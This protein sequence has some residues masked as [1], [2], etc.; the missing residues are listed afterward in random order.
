MFFLTKKDILSICEDPTRHSWPF[1]SWGKSR[2]RISEK[3]LEKVWPKITS[4][5]GIEVWDQIASAVYNNTT[6]NQS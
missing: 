2:S 1:L 5:V 6:T 4:P 3:L